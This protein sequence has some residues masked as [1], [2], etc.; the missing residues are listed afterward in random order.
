MTKPVII[1]E[2]PTKAKSITKY[3]SSRYVVLAS[4]GHVRDLPKN[5]LGVDIEKDFEPK[6]RVLSEKKDVIA[7]IKKAVASAEAVYLAPDPDREGEAIAWHI[8]EIIKGENQNI[9]RVL[10]NEIT[11]RGVEAGLAHPRPLDQQLFEAQQARRVLDRLV[12]YEL[13][14]L[15][16]KK[17]GR[18]LFAGR[19]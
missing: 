18:G 10:F 4:R 16:W 9:S 5:E 14:P 6:Y 2:S 7:A 19:V 12:G 8:Y 13:S 17:V 11:P 1:V 15:L 3:L